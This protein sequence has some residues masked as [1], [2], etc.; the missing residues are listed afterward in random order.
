MSTATP[1]AIRDRNIQ[2][3]EW[4]DP[5]SLTSTRFRRFR[6]EGGGDFRDAMLKAAPGAFR[7]FQV[8]DVGH[9]EP[10][11][12]SNTV[13]EEHRLTLEYVIAY[14]STHRYGPDNALDRDDI[15]DE[16]WDYIS[17]NIGIC[18]RVNY[19]GTYDCTPLGCTKEIERGEV[20]DFLVIR[21]EYLYQRA[22][23]VGGL[24][25]GVGG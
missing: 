11:T 20:C 5:V 16:D 21:A 24:A 14:P 9:D 2:L 18:G 19:S 4:V 25:Q 6:N 8:R 15:I 1:A 3:I 7:R 17:F 22:L 10:P 23:A 12:V 13:H